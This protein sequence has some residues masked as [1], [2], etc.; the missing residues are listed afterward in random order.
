MIL[1]AVILSIATAS[2]VPVVLESHGGPVPKESELR[3]LLA[4]APDADSAADLLLKHYQDHGFPAVGVEINDLDGQRHVDIDVARYEQILLGGGPE[5]TRKIAK[6]SFSTLANQFVDQNELKKSL[7]NFHANPLHRAVPRL[8][9]SADGLNVDALLRIEQSDA[10]QFSLGF[11]DTGAHPLP[12]E[13]YWIQGEFSDLWNLNSLTTARLTTA[14]RPKEFHAAQL[15][16]RFFLANENE[17]GVSLSY[18]GA[19]GKQISNFDAYTWQVGMQWKGAE[20]SLGKWKRQSLAGLSY[21]KTNNALEFREFRNRGL[22]DVF[23]LTLG[24]TLERQWDSGLTRINGSLVLS[25]F[26]DDDE[27]SVLRRGAKGEY[28]LARLAVWHRQDLKNDWDLVANLGSQWA[29]DPVLQADQLAL[30]GASGIR[31][32]PEQFG[33]G[34]KGYLGG[35]ELRAPVIELTKS[36][37]LRPSIFVQSGNTIDMVTD[38]HTSATTTGLGLQLGNSDGLRASVYSAWRLDEGGS[39]IHSQLSWKF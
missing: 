33:L 24:Q 4:S 32:L 18:S 35:L 26:G 12:R 38:T 15:G 8:Q 39:E 30:G 28:G 17:L 7:R 23:H 11:H 3:S 1:R 36:W 20:A 22:A 31:G 37:R 34:D 16:T 10:H 19:L 9:P 5:R 21:R 25:P 29:S 2:A 6:K 13:R 14:I 27:H